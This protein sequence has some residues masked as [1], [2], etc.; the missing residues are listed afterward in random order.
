MATTVGLHGDIKTILR[1]LVH[2]DFDAIEAYQAAIERVRDDDAKVTLSE[3]KGDF[4]RH[5][6]DVGEQLRGLGEDPPEGPDAKRLITE[7]KVVIAGLVGGDRAILSA[8]RSNEEDTNTAYERASARDDL[9]PELQLLLRR[10]LE[11]ARRH[12][13]WIEQRLHA[14][15][16]QSS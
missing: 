16:S 15:G 14:N 8:M 10:N 1:Q 5:V 3:F 2:L 11:D 4:E 13:G 6:Q 12:R 9:S 7:G